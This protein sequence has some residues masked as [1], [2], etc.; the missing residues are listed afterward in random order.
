MKRYRKTLSFLLIITLLIQ[1]IQPKRNISTGAQ[2][3]DI[4]KAYVIPVPVHRTFKHKCYDCHSN[5]TRYPWYFNVQ[6]IG[7]WLAAHIYD[8]KRHLN[9]SEFKKYERE[10]AKQKLNEIVEAVIARDMPI[11]GY[12]LLRPHAELTE[13]DE[14]AIQLWVQTV[15]LG[16]N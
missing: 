5:H 11:K 1:F 2:E 12:V 13:E 4:S 16:D 14:K 7:W 6:P 8:G 3:D 9:F 15:R 10:K